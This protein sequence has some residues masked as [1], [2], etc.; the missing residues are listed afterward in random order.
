VESFR[1]MT[2]RDML[3]DSHPV[4]FNGFV[5]DPAKCTYQES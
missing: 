3:L 1:A 2:E 4:E 5:V